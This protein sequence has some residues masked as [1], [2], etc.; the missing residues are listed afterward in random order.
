LYYKHSFCDDIAPYSNE[1][2][3]LDDI[4]TTRH[5]VVPDA[6]S[7]PLSF[8]LSKSRKIQAHYSEKTIKYYYMLMAFTTNKDRFL[9]HIMSYIPF[10]D[11][12]LNFSLNNNLKMNEWNQAVLFFILNH[13][14]IPA[15]SFDGPYFGP[16]KN[17]KVKK[18][19]SFL[20][21]VHKRK[22]NILFNQP[23]EPIGICLYE[24]PSSDVVFEPNSIVITNRIIPELDL[25]FEDKLK[26]YG[27]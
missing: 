5:I 4:L 8:A 19:L 23:V 14:S 17:D 26:I 7:L 2:K 20:A 11:N 12:F 10:D 24:F 6:K 1:L 13:Y 27:V 25:L 3:F 18:H 15:Q 16:E 21:S 9:E 22:F